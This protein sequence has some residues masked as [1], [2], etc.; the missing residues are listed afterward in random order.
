MMRAVRGVG[1][2]FGMCGNLLDGFIMRLM[3]TGER[4]TVGVQRL[5][6]VVKMRERALNRHP[7]PA[8]A[9]QC[10]QTEREQQINALPG[11]DADSHGDNHQGHAAAREDGQAQ[12]ERSQADVVLN[13]R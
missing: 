8:A 7:R 2:G 1:I 12:R 6:N 13:P 10:D 3:L 5:V 4:V 11:D 9:N